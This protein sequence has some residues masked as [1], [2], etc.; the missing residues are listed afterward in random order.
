[1]SRAQFSAEALA[2]FDSFRGMMKTALADAEITAS[3]ETF[4]SFIQRPAALKAALTLLKAA[5]NE[6]LLAKPSPRT[7]L[8]AFMVALFPIDILEISVEQMEA[9]GDERILDREC[10]QLAQAIVAIVTTD[11]GDVAGLLTA[12]SSFQTKF[13]EWKEFDRQR[14]LQSLANTHHQWVASLKHLEDSRADTRDPENL[15]VMVE[16]VERQLAVNKRRILQMGGPDALEQVLASPPITI[17]LDQIMMEMSSKKYWED[18]GAELRQMPPK[19]DR[20]VVLLNEIRDRLKQLVSSRSDI[21]AGIDRSMDVDFIRQM[22]EFGSF[23]S[24]SFFRVFDAIW[25]HLKQFGAASAEQEWQE[26]RDTIMAKATTGASTYDVLLP[27]IFNR[28]LKQLDLIEDA[29]QRYR[30]MMSQR[31]STPIAAGSAA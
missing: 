14:L 15:Q 19:Y 17:D 30:A 20:I 10:Y 23:D 25:S 12:L 4:S 27:E 1:M 3:F 22:I 9:A 21:Q 13:A 26:W 2:Q 16:S 6:E 11:A 28:F 5:K 8:A 29:T 18:F 7:M 24:E 31:G